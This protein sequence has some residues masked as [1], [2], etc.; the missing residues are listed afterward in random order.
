VGRYQRYAIERL[1]STR[2]PAAFLGG[3]LVLTWA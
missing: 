1:P 2:E 3:E